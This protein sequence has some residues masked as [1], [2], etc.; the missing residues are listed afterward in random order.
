MWLKQKVLMPSRT[1]AA[2][3]A[4]RLQ[5]M[6]YRVGRFNWPRTIDDL[7]G[8]PAGAN[9]SALAERGLDVPVHQNLRD[10][11]VDSMIEVLRAAAMG[12]KLQ[13]V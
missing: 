2:H 5:H 1:S 12:R 10:R 3:A 11:D 9:A 8:S 13:R 6:G 7:A 4:R